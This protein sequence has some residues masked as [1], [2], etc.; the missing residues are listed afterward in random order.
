MLLQLTREKQPQRGRGSTPHQQQALCSRGLPAP[1]HAPAP[2]RPS[3]PQGSRRDTSKSP[4]APSRARTQ[5]A[6]ACWRANR[7][8]PLPAR[9]AERPPAER[10]RAGDPG[11]RGPAAAGP[12][13]LRARPCALGAVVRCRPLPLTARGAAA[14][15]DY[16][17]QAAQRIGARPAA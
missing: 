11:G 17:S 3:R 10:S 16:K 7:A 9:S 5:A 12:R 13:G 4:E 8:T 6:T 15:G 1:P 14:A 2:P